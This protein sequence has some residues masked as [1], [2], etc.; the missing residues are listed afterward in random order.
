MKHMAAL[1]ESIPPLSASGTLAERVRDSLLLA[2]NSGVLPP[3]TRLREI[4]LSE[5]FGLSKTP[6]REGLRLLEADGVV[7]VNPRRGA[8]VTPLDEKV[9]Q[10]LYDLRFILETASARL[11]AESGAPVGPAELIRKQMAGHITDQPQ[12]VFHRLD[13]ELHHIL[14]AMSGNRELTD[15]ID[16]L[17]QRIQAA[18]VRSSVVARTKIAHAQHG[19][20]IEAI[21]RHD[22]DAAAEQMQQH[23]ESARLHVLRSLES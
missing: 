8:V 11:A 4:P 7:V 22:A 1:E 6:V 15:A 10:D 14:A 23:I 9:V 19:R 2:I 20:I 16:R 5:H 18:R 12:V 21:R 3:G 13:V 17:H